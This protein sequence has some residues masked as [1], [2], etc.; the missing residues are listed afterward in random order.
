MSRESVWLLRKKIGKS[1]AK[2]YEK[3]KARERERDIEPERGSDWILFGCL[4]NNKKIDRQDLWEREW[5]WD[6]ERKRRS[7]CRVNIFNRKI[8]IKA[9]CIYFQHL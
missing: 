2:T 4:E 6:I 8:A 3:A 1:T 5:E 7:D 9:T